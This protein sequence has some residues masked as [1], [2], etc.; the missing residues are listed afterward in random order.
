MKN[1]IVHASEVDIN[2]DTGMGRVEYYWKL[3]FEKAGFD[4]I[5]IGLK[6]TGKLRHKALFPLK[7]YE[8]YKKLN[9]A[10]GAFIIHEPISGYF[11]RKGTPCF[12]ESHGVERR[13]WEAVIN[14]QVPVEAPSLRT[15]LF[16][17]LW[18]LSVCDKGL[19]FADKLLLINSE[20]ENYVVKKY[21]HKRENIYIFKNGADS[22][23]KQLTSESSEFTVLFNGSW[24]D[25]KG[26]LTLINAAKLLF[27]QGILLK[28]LL[29][30][31]GKDI[32]TIVSDWPE[33]LR[34][35]IEVVPKFSQRDESTYLE[36]SSLFVL[37]SYFE[38]QPLSLLQA[39]AAGRCCITTN[40][41][42][43]K[44]IVR[45][46]IT[47]LLFDPGDSYQLACLIKRCYENESLMF[48]LGDNAKKYVQSLTWDAVSQEMVNYVI[49]STEEVILTTKKL[50]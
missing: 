27:S 12:V 46:G 34:K 41:C 37:P 39:M 4:F 3:A 9:V 16:Y 49:A 38:G 11:V 10:P 14:G 40:C 21:N 5:H 29:I 22:Y 20:D 26:I 1:V 31:T 18:R 13:Y 33:H 25:R 44:D 43:Q 35:W 23:D 24:I 45:N 42:G 36:A 28:Y 2:T 32:K 8:Y 50:I 47:G 30:G 6:E 7:A 48:Q 19:K 15:K 17:P